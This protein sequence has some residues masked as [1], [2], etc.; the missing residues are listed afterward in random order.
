VL[1]PLVGRCQH[2]EQFPPDIDVPSAG[3]PAAD[4]AAKAYFQQIGAA[5]NQYRRWN[6]SSMWRSRRTRIG[7]GVKAARRWK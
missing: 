2:P 5:V 4:A 6:W 7:G 1:N 3:L